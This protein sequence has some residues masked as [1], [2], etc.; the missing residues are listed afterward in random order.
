MARTPEKPQPLAPATSV[1]PAR[2]SIVTVYAASLLLGALGVT[3]AA[4]STL[5]RERLALG[6]TLYGAYFVPVY[7]L[8]IAVSLFATRLLRRSSMRAFFLS[9]SLACAAM[10][11][12]I[13]LAPLCGPSRGRALLFVATAAWGP[14]VGLLGIAVNTAAIG[15]FPRARSAALACLHAILAVGAA[16][17]P[18][19]IAGAIRVAFWPGALIALG[20]SFVVIALVVRLHALDGLRHA[21][22]A[23]DAGATA[24]PQSAE[25]AL[26]RE[27]SPARKAAP[28]RETA[29]EAR[30]PRR[31]WLRAA[32]AFV[33]GIGEAT[34]TAWAIVF[35]TENR[36]LPL[37]VAAGALSAFWI[38]MAAGRFAAALLVARMGSLAL[39]LLLSCGMALAF[40]LLP[41]SH[42]AWSAIARFALAGLSCSAL[43]PLLLGI[44]SHEFPARTAEVSALFAAAVMAGLAVGSFA[45]GPLRGPLGFERIFA[46]S[47]LGPALLVMLLVALARPPRAR[48][49]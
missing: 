13:A 44:C 35:L 17:W 47:A 42:D 2:L 7:A 32:S 20:A 6:D 45:L 39:A 29:P 36:S 4:S 37:A 41:G 48:A 3:F 15:L 9:G 8:A 23:R 22:E 21:E 24:A 38:A 10:L 11:L 14:G 25:A 1:R 26:A 19:A 12:L 31:L 33:Y 27:A 46:I 16:A 40:L 43:F 49:R 28:A 34:F 5:L 18:L 30:P